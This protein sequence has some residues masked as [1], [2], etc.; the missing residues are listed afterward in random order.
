M[1]SRWTSDATARAPSPPV[2][3]TFSI[4]PATRARNMAGAWRRAAVRCAGR[5]GIIHPIRWTFGIKEIRETDL[6][7]TSYPRSGNTWVRYILAYLQRGVQQPIS[8]NELGVLVPDAYHSV[9]LINATQGPR[10][11][12][13][14]EPFLEACPRVVY[15][16]R[17]YREAAVSYWLFMR[18]L[19]GY[20]GCFSEFLRG[21][22]PHQHG[23]WKEHALALRRRCSS[24]PGTIFV[25]PYDS[26]VN[27]FVGTVGRLVA[28]SGIGEGVDVA[29]VRRRTTLHALSE[30]ERRQGSQFNARTGTNFFADSGEG[31][32]WRAHWTAE[33]LAW[34]ARDRELLGLMESLGYRWDDG[35]R[36]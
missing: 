9:E 21:S 33:D 13:T 28:W 18:R 8:M 2:R 12:K 32:G 22:I 31:T 15:I 27:D 7:V 5:W 6:F 4:T 19:T 24:D 36:G 17:D 29:D 26:I 23:S 11:I 20:R 16:H 35:A 34:L 25:V 3:G 1:D 14:H 30:G 10:L